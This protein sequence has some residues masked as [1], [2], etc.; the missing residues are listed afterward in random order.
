L[1][2]AHTI[3]GAVLASHGNRQLSHALPQIPAFVLSLA[4]KAAGGMVGQS[5]KHLQGVPPHL[6]QLLGPGLYHHA[7]QGRGVAGCGIRVHALHSDDTKLAGAYWL[8]V[9]VVAESRDV[10]ACLAHRIH[11]GGPLGNLYLQ[12]IDLES[13]CRHVPTA[14]AKGGD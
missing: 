1:Q 8:E 4:E 7:L 2:L 3:L 13:N 12:T 11:D 9:R 14:P 10:Y 5:Q 6:L